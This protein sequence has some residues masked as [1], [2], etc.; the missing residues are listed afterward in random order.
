MGPQNR[1][2]PTASATAQAESQAKIQE[3]AHFLDN[4]LRPQMKTAKRLLETTEEEIA[5]YTKLMAAI[6][7]LYTT[8]KIDESIVMAAKQRV[9]LGYQTVYCKARVL[10]TEAGVVDE[11]AAAAEPSTPPPPASN[12]NSNKLFVHVGLG[13]HAELESKEA[14]DFCL[15]RIDF[16]KSNQLHPRQKVYTQVFDHFQSS[17]NILQE[18]EKVK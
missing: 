17:V 1:H 15:Q 16:L 13:F 2:P 14:M 6:Q 12:E 9:D 7:Q 3:Y 5:E 11:A 10:D 4:V 8:D 18:L